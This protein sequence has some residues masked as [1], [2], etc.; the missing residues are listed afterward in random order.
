MKAF[1]RTNLAILFLLISCSVNAQQWQTFDR[2]FEFG[3]RA[4]VNLSRVNGLKNPDISRVANK[5]SGWAEDTKNIFG[6]NLALTF[7]YHLSRKVYLSSALQFLT[8][9]TKFDF[10]EDRP[11]YILSSPDSKMNQ[12]YLQVPV[13]V[14][15][16]FQLS[17]PVRLSVH[18]GP[19]VSYGIGGHTERGDMIRKIDR[20]T[21]LQMGGEMS[22]ND[23]AQIEKGIAREADT[24]SD[25][26]LRRFDF[27]VGCGVLVEYYQIGFGLNYDF[28]LLDL[29]NAGDKVKNGVGYL[30]FGYKF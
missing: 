25:K 14:G 17:R 10:R 12:F 15:Y 19:Y 7:D 20:E 3:V 28:G 26:G 2:P 5:P 4:G 23:Y 11:Q 13:H 1:I 9:G 22:L 21:G 29:S 16:K 24:F 6:I 18:G 8:K 30:T 27:G